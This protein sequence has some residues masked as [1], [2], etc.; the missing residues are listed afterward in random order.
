[1]R[2]DDGRVLS[3][4]I[5]QALRGEALTVHG[6]GSHTRSYCAVDDLVTGILAV[7]GSTGSGPFNLGATRELTVLDLAHAVV[8]A[9]GSSSPVQSM[10]MP[11]ERT[12][13]PQ[14]RQPD[15]RNTIAECGWQPTTT[16]EDGL[17]IMIAA[18]RAELDG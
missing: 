9:V 4:F 16:L 15:L 12:G 2:P 17:A 11:P 5:T 1:M 3:T 8:A 14:R 13:D 10:P 18:L 7:A 6:D